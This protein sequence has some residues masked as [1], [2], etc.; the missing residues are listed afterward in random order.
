MTAHPQDLRAKRLNGNAE[1]FWRPMGPVFPMIAAAPSC[2]H[3]HAL[4]VRQVI[5]IIGLRFPFE[6]HGVEVHVANVTKFSLEAFSRLA[7]EH[8]GG[9]AAAAN[10][11]FLAVNEKLPIA[12]LVEFGR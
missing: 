4:L 3:E 2:H 5:E 1:V 9:P 10:Q 7:E 6:A 11:D 8:V 12:M